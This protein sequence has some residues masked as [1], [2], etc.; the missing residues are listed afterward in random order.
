MIHALVFFLVTIL[1]IIA[2]GYNKPEDQSLPLSRQH[3]TMLR[4]ISILLIMGGHVSGAFIDSWQR[5]LTPLGG[6]RCCSVLNSQW[7]W[8]K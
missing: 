6:G 4:G 2:L 1:L 5:F 7:L 3:T 8:H